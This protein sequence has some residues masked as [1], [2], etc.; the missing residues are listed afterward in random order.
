MEK[1]MKLFRF[2]TNVTWHVCSVIAIFSFSHVIMALLFKV[3]GTRRKKGS[4]R[5][6]VT[7]VHR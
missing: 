1:E 5:E 6:N 7:H 3:H 4:R 2:P